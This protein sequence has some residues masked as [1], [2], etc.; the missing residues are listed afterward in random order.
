MVYQSDQT[1]YKLDNF[2][3][4]GIRFAWWMDNRATEY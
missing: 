2:L 4:H 3:I 1:F